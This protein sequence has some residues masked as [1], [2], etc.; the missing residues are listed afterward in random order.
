VSIP[1]SKQP[2]I[3]YNGS[4]REEVVEYYFTTTTPNLRWRRAMLGDSTR[5]PG[6][7][8]RVPERERKW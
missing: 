6:F 8:E 7:K 1:T 5:W 4:T 3:V 2:G